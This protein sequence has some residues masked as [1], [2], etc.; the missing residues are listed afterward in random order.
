MTCA[1][2]RTLIEA[3]LDGELDPSREADLLV[4]L[5]TCSD[6]RQLLDAARSL[7]KTMLEQA[8][9]YKAPPG[10]KARIVAETRKARVRTGG[11]PPFA[12]NWL[13]IA[14]SVL[15]VAS[16]AGN[17]SLVR[18]RVSPAEMAA[19][20]VLSSH[21]R[22]L[23]GTHLLDVP[24]S[25]QHTVKP[26]FDGRLDFSPDVKDFA[27]DGFP[28][29]GGRLEYLDG[30]PAAALVFQRRKHVV[31]LFTWP[32][33][34]SEEETRTTRN[35]Y[36]LIRWTKSGMTYWAVSDLNEAELGQFVELYRK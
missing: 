35:G 16:V 23:S 7:K 12:W 19:A 3:H 10:L 22:S 15:L 26:W 20:S 11:K 34:G 25:D 6:C 4:H 9:Y 32:V 2:I 21:V 17:I 1:S 24:S 30:H 8:P 29:T 5:E 28:L 18:S 36:H 13:A 31:N 33:A 27:V 14:A